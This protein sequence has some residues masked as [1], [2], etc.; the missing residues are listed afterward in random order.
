MNVGWVGVLAT[1][2]AI[3]SLGEPLE[4]VGTLADPAIREASGIVASRRHPGIFWVHNDS[5]NGPEL[6]AVRRSGALVR[7]YRVAAPNLDWEDIATDDAGHLYLADI[8]NNKL[9]LPVRV[10][11]QIDEP[12]PAVEPA[13][14]QSLAVV[15]SHFFRYPDGTPFDAE[16]LVIRDRHA[17]IV[18][19]RLDGQPA[20]IYELPL[21]RPS[22]LLRP[23]MPTR[24][25]S[26]PG[27]AKA[28]TGADLSRDGRRLAVVTDRSVLVYEVK[29]NTSWD[30]SLMGSMSI[31]ER[32]IEA[33]AW[34]G[35]ALILASEDRSIYRIT[36]ERWRRDRK[37]P[38]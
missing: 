3:S 21:D 20:V 8:G 34:D 12:D 29:T 16:A 37:G 6:F 24:V 23:L 2:V 38:R 33:I 15:S 17:L 30:W 14:G 13:P 9:V 11:H 19:K 25:G 27:N 18:S 22:P 10:L 36:P 7:S 5:G 31:E 28:V 32:D 4:R 35:A 1:L 26:L